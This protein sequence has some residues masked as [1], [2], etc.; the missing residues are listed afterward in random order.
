MKDSE[1]IR[2]TA[3]QQIIKAHDYLV[4]FVEL[5]AR[6]KRGGINDFMELT[7]ANMIRKAIEKIDEYLACGHAT[8]DAKEVM[9]RAIDGFQVVIDDVKRHLEVMPEVKLQ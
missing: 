3:E 4:G 7:I 9:T 5:S 8:V 6:T 1:Q 2:L